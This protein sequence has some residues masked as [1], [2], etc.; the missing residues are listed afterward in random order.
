MFP[1]RSS[2]IRG[3]RALLLP[4]SMSRTGRSLNGWMRSMCHICGASEG[5]LS[6]WP[7]GPADVVSL[8]E[9]PPRSL[10]ATKSVIAAL[11]RAPAHFRGGRQ[12]SVNDVVRARERP[13]LRENDP[14]AVSPAPDGARNDGQSEPS[15][16]TSKNPVLSIPSAFCR[17]RRHHCH[18]G[19]EERF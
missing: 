11:I 19:D 1:Y 12:K 7:R 15:E 6:D 5:I 2:N 9:D 3:M 18:R 14:P 17:F 4:S 10:V 8:F 16:R 13:F